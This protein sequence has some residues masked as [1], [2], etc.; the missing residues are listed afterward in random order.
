MMNKLLLVFLVFIVVFSPQKLPSLIKEISKI[1]TKYS[2]FR[3]KLI[4]FWN[5]NFLQE[6]ILEENNKKAQVADDLYLEKNTNQN[7]KK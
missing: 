5:K 4:E 2:V 3:K 7:N 1:V 6:L